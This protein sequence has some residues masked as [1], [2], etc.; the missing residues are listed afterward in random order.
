MILVS[1]TIPVL[2][3]V[4]VSVLVLI[5]ASVEISIT[6]LSKTY[7]KTSIGYL[8]NTSISTNTDT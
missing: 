8:T 5:L 6:G 2:V 7:T 1:V 4:L 3:S